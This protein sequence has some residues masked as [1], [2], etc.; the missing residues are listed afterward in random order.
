DAVR[1]AHGGVMI[2]RNGDIRAHVASWERIDDAFRALTE[3]PGFRVVRSPRDYARWVA[4]KL[5]TIARFYEMFSEKS[6]I[7]RPVDAFVITR[8][9][10]EPARAVRWRDAL[11]T[12]LRR[13][14]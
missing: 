9:G 14:V 5:E 13:R 12:V 1:F 7:G 11:R 2:Y 3:T 4:F 8:R 10:I 6:I